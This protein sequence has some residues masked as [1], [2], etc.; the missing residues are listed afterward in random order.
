MAGEL[1]G[2]RAVTDRRVATLREAIRTI[3]LE[4]ADPAFAGSITDGLARIDALAGKRED[5]SAR[6]LRVG[7]VVTFFAP[8]ILRFLDAT[9]A[10]AVLADDLDTAQ[11]AVAYGALQQLEAAGAELRLYAAQGFAAGSFDLDTYRRVVSGFQAQFLYAKQVANALSGERRDAFTELTNSQPFTDAQA[12]LLAVLTAPPG[13]PIPEVTP[14]SWQATATERLTRLAEFETRV[15]RALKATAEANR[16]SGTNLFRLTLAG[17]CALVLL[18]VLFGVAVARSISAPLSDLA[19]TMRRLADGT[20]DLTIPHHGRRDEIGAMARTVAV[21]QS[22]ALDM[23]R[24]QEEQERAKARAEGERRATLARV[25][26]D[27]ERSVKGVVDSV[28][29]AAVEMQAAA[30]QLGSAA[31]ETARHGESVSV[32]TRQTSANVQS[33]ASATDEL[34]ASIGEIGRQVESS[35]VIARG[36]VVQADETRSAVDGLAAAASRIGDVIR[37]I[38]EIASQTNLLALNATIEAA[39]AG[40][41]GKGFAVVASEVKGLANQTAKSTEEIASQ[42]ASIQAATTGTVTAIQGIGA[43]IKRI[44]EIASTIAAAVQQQ[45]AA[46]QDIARNVG[47]AATGADDIAHTIQRVHDAAGHTATASVQ[48]AGSSSELSMQAENLRAQMDGFLKTL[49]TG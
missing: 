26:E 43:T 21:F 18:T 44:D 2:L 41:A 3:D 32:V 17:A 13:T 4:S 24:L 42:I 46:T 7:A 9:A 23:R 19:G 11:L 6:K 22:N 45:M 10:L 20:L 31:E 38:Q 35:A 39:R 48:V 5:I 47:Q 30:R 34:T 36:A 40:D 8:T 16:A 37:L 33:V 28:A 27:F 25:A 1:P 29:S 12:M 15:E 49:R 14:A